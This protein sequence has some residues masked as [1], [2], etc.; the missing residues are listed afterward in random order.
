MF[1]VVMTVRKSN[2]HH[3][4]H[5]RASKLKL[6]EHFQRVPV[7]KADFDALQANLKTFL[8]TS[9]ELV[10][11]GMIGSAPLPTMVEAAFQLCW[12][13]VQSHVPYMVVDADTKCV[14]MSN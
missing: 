6:G 7:K 10:V 4:K 14:S 9:S 5:Q 8:K 13:N 12:P 3:L 1:T 11:G 2:L